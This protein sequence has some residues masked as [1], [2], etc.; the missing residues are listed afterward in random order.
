MSTN[1]TSDDLETILRQLANESDTDTDPKLKIEKYREEWNRY[2]RTQQNDGQKLYCLA[3]IGTQ[4]SR[5]TKDLTEFNKLEYVVTKGEK[6]I[7]RTKLMRLRMAE[8][9]SD[10]FSTNPEFLLEVPR[11]T[12]LKLGCL[13]H[14]ELQ[15]LAEKVKE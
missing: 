15:Q 12:F 9:L 14:E 4:I 10:I 5:I 3:L 2:A 11:G 8:W 13:N 7:F 6:P 1:E